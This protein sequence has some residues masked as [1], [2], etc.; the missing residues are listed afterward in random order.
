[1]APLTPHHPPLREADALERAV[2][3]L[4]ELLLAAKLI[5]QRQSRAMEWAEMVFTLSS[6]LMDHAGAVPSS[7]K[8]RIIVDLLEAGMVRR[9]MAF[10]VDFAS[11]NKFCPY[12]LYIVRI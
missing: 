8:L 11:L 2:Q 6:T 10:L 12:E 1:M 3:D 7:K 9:H 5:T 4:K